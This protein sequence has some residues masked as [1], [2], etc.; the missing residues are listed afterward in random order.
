[1]HTLTQLIQDRIHDLLKLGRL[2]GWYG[3]MPLNGVTVT[4]NKASYIVRFGHVEVEHVWPYQ[5]VSIKHPITYDVV[6]LQ[7]DFDILNEVCREFGV[8]N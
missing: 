1:M 8:C 6:Q 7:Q 2:R 5:H 3:E 4:I